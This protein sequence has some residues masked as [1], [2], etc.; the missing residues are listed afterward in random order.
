MQFET[1]P[2]NRG[3]RMAIPV[4]GLHGAKRIEV[5]L[6]LIAIAGV[7]LAAF[8]AV[9]RRSLMHHTEY[10]LF[11]VGTFILY[12][13]TAVLAAMALRRGRVLWG[14][15]TLAHLIV[16]VTIFVFQCWLMVPFSNWRAGA[17]THHEACSA[18]AGINAYIA[19]MNVITV[20]DI[21]GLSRAD[22]VPL[23]IFRL[24]PPG[25]ALVWCGGIV[26]IGMLLTV[27][28]ES[29]DDFIADSGVG[30]RFLL[31][32]GFAAGSFLFAL[33]MRS[34]N[35]SLRWLS[36]S[37]LF[38]GLLAA[39][40]GHRFF[41][42]SLL[43]IL[44]V[45]RLICKPPSYRTFAT[46]AALCPFGYMALLIAAYTRQSSRPPLA[47]LASLATGGE[48]FEAVMEYA[49]GNEQ[50][51]FYTFCFVEGKHFFSFGQYYFISLLR[52]LPNGIYTKLSDDARLSIG[53]YLAEQCAPNW[54]LDH[55]LTL[56]GYFFCEAYVNFG[57][58][59][60]YL[61]LAMAYWG[62][63]FMEGVRHNGKI[64][65][66]LYVSAACTVLTLV[67]YGLENFL[68]PFL[69]TTVF[70]LV[71]SHFLVEHADYDTTE[72][73]LNASADIE[74]NHDEESEMA[75]DLVCHD[76]L[77]IQERVRV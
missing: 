34:R 2:F 3:P 59:G 46:L 65:A 38:I 1:L 30:D 36:R 51:T 11:I 74:D 26:A 49:G 69:L 39:I 31:R 67:L 72:T 9:F 48:S 61:S 12:A 50:C 71:I 73:G 42:F 70:A 54:F 66:L 15:F 6:A 22:S 77:D 41:L 58:I 19:F 23:K 7:C 64:G 55:G 24:T 4:T 8:Q 62:S 10:S 60:P 76:E 21:T 53:H 14:L 16:P 52:M 18:I 56:G 33:T 32:F 37:L 13:S 40:L 45:T 68:K 44:T 35:P 25:K 75:T 28:R 5:S 27:L 17:I 63:R 43:L 20:W 29:R 47:T 57:A